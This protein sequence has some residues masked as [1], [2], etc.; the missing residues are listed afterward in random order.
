M[1]STLQCAFSRTRLKIHCI[2][3]QSQPCS[4]I[5]DP[6]YL[7][8]PTHGGTHRALLVLR[9]ATPCQP[10]QSK[11]HSTFS[12]APPARS[13]PTA[14]TKPRCS[15]TIDRKAPPIPPLDPPCL[16]AVLGRAGLPLSA[17]LLRSVR[18][19]FSLDVCSFSCRA[20]KKPWRMLVGVLATI[21]A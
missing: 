9:V 10:D 1:Y 7:F 12:L 13:Q 14:P 8:P 4:G 11:C 21:P 3:S 16:D 20:L 15:I 19:S 2:F 18:T 6:N 5:E 17:P